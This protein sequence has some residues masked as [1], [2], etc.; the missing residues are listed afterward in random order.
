MQTNRA[1]IRRA[2][3]SFS[4]PGKDQWFWLRRIKLTALKEAQKT[5]EIEFSSSQKRETP[6]RGFFFIFLSCKIF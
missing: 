5:L 2:E 6:V 1:E 3:S 4:L